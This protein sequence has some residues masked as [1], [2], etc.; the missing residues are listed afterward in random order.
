MGEWYATAYTLT[1]L[2]PI[3]IKPT[4]LT[5]QIYYQITISM[6]SMLAI[7][8]TEH[9]YVAVSLDPLAVMLMFFTSQI[10]SREKNISPLYLYY[11]GRG[12]NSPTNRVSHQVEELL[13]QPLNL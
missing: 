7:V 6:S 12:R 9:I 5:T 11:C 1:N 3:L 2:S 4:I 10:R 13:S 8:T